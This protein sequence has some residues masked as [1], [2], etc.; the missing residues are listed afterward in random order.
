MCA[1][2][3]YQTSDPR[4]NSRHFECNCLCWNRRRRYRSQETARTQGQAIRYGNTQ[5]VSTQKC[6]A[7]GPSRLW[8]INCNCLENVRCHSVT[9][10]N[11]LGLS[12]SA[13][14]SIPGAPPQL[15]R[16]VRPD[17]HNMRSAHRHLPCPSSLSLDA[18][19]YASGSRTTDHWDA[20]ESDSVRARNLSCCGVPLSIP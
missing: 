4:H 13:P 10:F 12:G 11:S 6:M 1:E 5:S 18:G 17:D 9:F 7:P 20:S 2:A 3:E 14:R 19:G 16:M 8:N 15:T